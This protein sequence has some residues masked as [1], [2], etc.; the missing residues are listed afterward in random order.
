MV[1]VVWIA[2]LPEDSSEA[3]EGASR[4]FHSV[5]KVR[6]YYEPSGRIGR[7]I[8]A[9][10]GADESGIAWDIYLLY[11]RDAEWRERPPRPG[12]WAHQLGDAHW[13]DRSKYYVGENLTRRL[14]EMIAAEGQ[15][16]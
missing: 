6:Q 10:L 11:E 14:R 1:M 8:A 12:D 15:D 4:L 16:G 9:M 7:E 3:A 5:R 2:I 13:A